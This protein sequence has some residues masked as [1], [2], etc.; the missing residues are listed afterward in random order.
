[1]QLKRERHPNE[2]TLEAYLVGSLPLREAKR[3]EE[4]VLAC[5]ECVGASEELE[6]YIRS[7]RVALDL[8]K[9]KLAIAR[10]APPV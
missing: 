7:M 9:P 2:Q 8:G 4:H 5:P 3:I 6:R 1:M 10:K